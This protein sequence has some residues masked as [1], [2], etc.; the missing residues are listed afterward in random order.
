MMM[1]LVVPSKTA[2]GSEEEDKVGGRA[3][4]TVLIRE[5]LDH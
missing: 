3:S 5:Q 4:S 1:N 2:G